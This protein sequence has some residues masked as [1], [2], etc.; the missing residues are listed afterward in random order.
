MTDDQAVR[1]EAIAEEYE[2]L[3]F[4][5][6]IRITDQASVLVQKNSLCFLER[7]AMLY[8]VRSSFAAIPGKFNIAHIIILAISN[9]KC[10]FGR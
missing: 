9:G 3:C 10:G 4:L 1:L 7:D 5:R 6:V 2:A 8:Q